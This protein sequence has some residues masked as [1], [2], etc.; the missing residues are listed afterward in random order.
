[1]TARTPTDSAREIPEATVARLPSISAA[2]T[3]LAEGGTTT[4]SSE[5][6]AT[7]AGVNSAKLRKDRLSTWAA[8]AYATWGTT[9]TTCAT[10]LPARS[11]SQDWPV[12]IVGVSNLGHA[13]ASYSGF[14]SGLRI[15]WPCWTPTL[16]APRRGGGIGQRRSYGNLEQPCATTASR[17][18]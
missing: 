9:W 18:G 10:R 15:A 4:C 3:T 8:T 14:R 1:M 16:D 6:L 7:A 12:V 11:A 13:L 17:S 5:Q 2:L